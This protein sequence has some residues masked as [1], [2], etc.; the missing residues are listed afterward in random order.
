MVN[1][2]GC[3]ISDTREVPKS[4]RAVRFTG[5]G[6]GNLLTGNILYTPFNEPVEADEAAGLTQANNF[7]G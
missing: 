3:T 6:V 4:R 1:I 7:T 5:K 2:N